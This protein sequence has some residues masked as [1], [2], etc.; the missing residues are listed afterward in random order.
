[1]FLAWFFAVIFIMMSGLFTPIESMPQWVK[2]VNIVNPIAY[3]IQIM[4]MVML[5]GSELKDIASPL[6]SIV[7][8]AIVSLTLAVVRYRKVSA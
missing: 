3:F 7:I 4:R 6:L 2:Y 5:K 1:M 8:Y